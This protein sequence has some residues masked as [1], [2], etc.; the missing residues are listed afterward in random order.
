MVMMI[1]VMKKETAP[2]LSKSLNNSFW[3]KMKLEIVYNVWN[4]TLLVELWIDYHYLEPLFCMD[5]L[6]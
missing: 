4:M 2:Y 5:V 6:S 3:D 1:Q